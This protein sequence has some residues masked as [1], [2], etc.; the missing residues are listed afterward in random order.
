MS[1]R[2]GSRA[3]SWAER[4]AQGRRPGGAPPRTEEVAQATAALNAL[5]N[6]F[7][8]AREQANEAMSAADGE[9]AGGG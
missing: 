6:L 3:G 9:V 5:W 7:D 2:S 1:K 4:L 8:E